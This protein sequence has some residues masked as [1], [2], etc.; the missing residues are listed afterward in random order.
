M[1]TLPTLPPEILTPDQVCGLLKI[2]AKTLYRWRRLPHGPL[3]AFRPGGR[4][5]YFEKQ[6]VL[7]WLMAQRDRPT[8]S[9]PRKARKARA[10]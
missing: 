7:D 1:S 6:S 4:R 8:I 9:T 2:D 5:L 3:P 10:S